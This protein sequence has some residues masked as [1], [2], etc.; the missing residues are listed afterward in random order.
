LAKDIR[1]IVREQLDK[2]LDHLKSVDENQDDAIRQAR[3]RFKKVRSVLRLARGEL[4][5]KAFHRENACY[6]DAG[7]QFSPFRD[8]VVMDQTLDRLA[9]R[10]A[11]RLNA[12][13]CVEFHRILTASK[14]QRLLV[15]KKFIVDVTESIEDA[16]RRAAKWPIKRDNFS[17]FR[18]G[19]K[20]AYQHGRRR[21]AHSYSHPTVENFHEWRK[22]IAYLRDMARVL[23][24]IRQDELS[25]LA[26]RLK[27]LETYLGEYHD[28][29]VLRMGFLAAVRDSKNAKKAEPFLAMIKKRQTELQA[30]ARPLGERVYAEKPKVFLARIEKYWRSGRSPK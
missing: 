9:R 15:E 20:D 5:R 2:A 6:R 16:R 24:P 8:A 28:L 7:L 10:Y 22:Q 19:L 11:K 21:M 25:K 13:D 27:R 17:V 29:A 23:S 1:R 18:D 26:D 14:A 30:T 12:A 3:R 4:G